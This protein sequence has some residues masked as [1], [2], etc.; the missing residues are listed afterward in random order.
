[1]I[2]D[3]VFLRAWYSIEPKKLYN[4]VT[5]LLLSDKSGWQGMRLTGQ[6]RRDEGIRTPL[7]ANS[8]YRVSSQRAPGSPTSNSSNINSAHSTFYSPLQSP[9]STSQTRSLAPL[10]Q[11]DQSHD[12]AKETYLPPIPSCHNGTRREEGCR[13]ITTDSGVKKGQDGT[14]CFEEGG[15]AKRAP[16]R[17]GG[18]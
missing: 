7:D 6:L 17:C 5:S 8:N 10:C 1:M 9:Q 2:S 13:A 16:K 3:I 15:E 14:T 18:N 11:Q 12:Q 4:P